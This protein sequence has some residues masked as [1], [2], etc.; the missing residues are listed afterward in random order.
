MFH[1]EN[2]VIRYQ[3]EQND[4]DHNKPYPTCPPPG[5]VLT[6]LSSLCISAPRRTFHG[7]RIIS[8][9]PSGG[10]PLGHPTPPPGTPG[11][12][13]GPNRRDR[14]HV[15]IANGEEELSPLQVEIQGRTVLNL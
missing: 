12:R 9:A 8:G 15:S 7:L 5:R 11:P 2:M 3:I 1:I 6:S 10:G 14:D 4:L 13:R